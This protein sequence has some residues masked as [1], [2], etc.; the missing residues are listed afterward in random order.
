MTGS[1]AT[2]SGAIKSLLE[3]L[4]AGLQVFRSVAPPKAH[5]P[6]CVITEDV[7]WL[8]LNHGDTDV[9][10]EMPV[11]EQVQVDIYQ[12][13]RGPDGERTENV[14]L[15]HN[16]CFALLN[17]R[18]P[19]WVN[20]VYGVRILNRSTATG[21]AATS[22]VRRTILTLE[23]DWVFAERTPDPRRVSDGRQRTRS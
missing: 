14:E 2:L 19:T 7:S 3:Q 4:G 22:N 11:R 21:D 18:L 13:L 12:A 9:T 16:I 1:N 10:T 5:M 23:V 15:E 8:V 20:H 17:T 6:F